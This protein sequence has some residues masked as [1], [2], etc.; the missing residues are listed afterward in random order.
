MRLMV[1]TGDHGRGDATKWSGGYTEDDLVLHRHMVASLESLG[2]FDL[3]VCSDHSRLLSRLTKPPPDLVLNFCD[4]GFGNQAERELHI[5]ALLELSAIPY[6]GAGPQAMVLAYDKRL[7]RHIA[8]DLGIPVPLERVVMAG[9]AVPRDAVPFPAFVKPA[10]GDGSVGIN[11]HARVAD[12]AALEEQVNWLRQQRPGEP[13]LIQE[14]LPGDEYG[15]GLLGHPPKPLPMLRVDYSS[16]PADLPPILAFESK[17]GPTSPYESVDI[18]EAALSEAVTTEL[19][20]HAVRL[21]ERIG[22]R[23]YARFDFRADARGQIKL[24]EVNPNPA[25]SSAAK[26]ARMAGFAG[27]DYPQMLGAIVDAARARY[28]LGKGPRKA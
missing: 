24:M 25:W 22:C 5:P 7:V 13:V 20:T 28:G 3:E 15:L 26:L 16:L 12:A 4:T 23:D 19:A 2:R 10:S 21:F 14:F 6:T 1:I 17:T 27:M 9:E 8:A 18:V 11:R